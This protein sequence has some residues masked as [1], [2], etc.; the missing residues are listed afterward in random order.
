MGGITIIF[1][2]ESIF[3]IE[4]ITIMLEV[5][6]LMAGTWL[7]LGGELVAE[8]ADAASGQGDAPLGKHLEHEAEHARRLLRQRRQE[9]ALFR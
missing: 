1:R 5:I 8:R 9:D 4:V 3:A 7:E 2:M 6:F